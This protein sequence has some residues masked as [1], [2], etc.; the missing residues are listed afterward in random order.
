M[1]ANLRDDFR[2][3]LV[4]YREQQTKFDQINQLQADL[5]AEIIARATALR[6][7]KA[8]VLDKPGAF[9]WL[10]EKHPELLDKI[11][12]PYE[13]TAKEIW[14]D[15]NEARKLL[16]DELDRLAQLCP[17]ESGP[18]WLEVAHSHSSDYATQGLGASG[19]ARASMLLREAEAKAAGVPTRIVT[20]S[21]SYPGRSGLTQ[22]LRGL[23]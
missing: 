14:A 18:L 8:K 20:T 16:G 11:S 10:R 15:Y 9:C 12:A 13:A 6:T 3:T 21:G 2:A 1:T 5:D 17:V 22:V 7:K 4:E 23:T 19:Y